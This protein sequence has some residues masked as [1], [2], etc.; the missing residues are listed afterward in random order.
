MMNVIWVFKER[1]LNNCLKV[2]IDT[3]FMNKQ[4]KCIYWAARWYSG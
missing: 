1:Y 4:N 3:S 2:Q